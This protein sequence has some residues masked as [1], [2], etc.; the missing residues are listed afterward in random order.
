MSDYLDPNNQELLN[1]FFEE[2]NLQID[3]LEQNILVLEDRFDDKDAID[4]L[5]RAAHTLKGAAATVQM[6]EVTNFTHSLEDVLDLVRSGDVVVD[7]E[8]VDIFLSAIDIIKEMIGSREE[9]SIFHDEYIF[10]VKENLDLL[11][12]GE[13]AQNTPKSVGAD[14]SDYI[15][16]ATQAAPACKKQSRITDEYEYIELF[17]LGGKDN[18]IYE[19]IVQFDEDALMNTVGGIQ[20]YTVLKQAGIMLKTTPDFEELN[21]DIFHPEVVY[22]L[23]SQES[24]QVI[25]SQLNLPDVVISHEVVTLEKD[26]FYDPSVNT[27]EA[28]CDGDYQIEEETQHIEFEADRDDREDDVIVPKKKMDTKTSKVSTSI[29][30]VESKRIDNLLNLVS[31]SVINKSTINR[32]ALD[33]AES[34]SEVQSFAIKFE[35]DVYSFLDSAASLL[36][37]TNKSDEGKGFISEGREKFDK[38]FFDLYSYVNNF[39]VNITDLDNTAQKL[40]MNTSNLQEGIMKI[41][42]VPISNIFSRFPRLVR[43]LS[44]SL[45]KKVKLVLEGENTELDKSVIEDLLDPLIHCVRNSI[46]H[47]IETPDIRDAHGKNEEGTIVLRA[48]NEGSMIFIEVTDDGAGI[49]KDKVLKRAKDRGFIKSDA[50]LSDSDIYNLLFLPGFSTVDNVSNVSGRGVGMDVVKTQIEKLKGSITVTSAKGKGTTFSIRLPLTLSIIKGLLVRVGTEIYSIPVANVVDSHRVGLSDINI[51]DNYE[52]FNVREE[53]V[54]VVRLN[55]LFNI[56]TEDN[57]SHK[58]I[59]IVSSGDKKMG[60]VVDQLIGEE[61]VV[62]KPLKDDFAN[63]PGVAGATILGDGKVSLIIDVS[64]LLELGVEKHIINMDNW[65]NV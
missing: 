25:S 26:G 18:F 21:E 2:A 27:E 61:D 39:K 36:N 64:R 9:G 58:Y 38:I 14:V 48:S 30:R 55:N 59:V 17:E 13:L 65:S 22:Y 56:P 7:E 19:V 3:L 16:S 29:L 45:G 50:S 63:T 4:E 54:F 41:R 44:N 42:M 12:S 6:D 15:E 20:A 34:L 10:E 24:P 8:G 47:G 37:H 35:N 11:A 51:V 49:D 23:A 1:D 32:V 52:V 43:D 46:D 53:V 60:L 5:F 31:E 28:D 33:L 57:F 62:I 40:S